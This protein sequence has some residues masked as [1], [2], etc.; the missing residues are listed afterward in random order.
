MHMHTEVAIIF[1]S[2]LSR[3][4]STFI[5]MSS[6]VL[7]LMLILIINADSSVANIYI[8]NGPIL[9]HFF[10]TTKGDQLANDFHVYFDL[11]FVN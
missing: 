6:D 4:N 10:M 11:C 7:K 5:V 3:D 1:F 9:C 2:F 8:V